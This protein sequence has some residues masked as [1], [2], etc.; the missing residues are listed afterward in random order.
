MELISQVYWKQELLFADDTLCPTLLY[1]DEYRASFDLGLDKLM[2]FSS[3][4]EDE[5]EFNA[6]SDLFND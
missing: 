5:R 1:S 2:N 4:S 6:S 3:D